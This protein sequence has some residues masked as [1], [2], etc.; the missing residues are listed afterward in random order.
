MKRELRLCQKT[1][2]GAG[3]LTKEKAKGNLVNYHTSFSHVQD[4][5][6][7]KLDGVHWWCLKH[8]WRTLRS[9]P[10]AIQ[11]SQMSLLLDASR[12][13]GSSCRLSF[14]FNQRKTLLLFE[15]DYSWSH[16]CTFLNLFTNFMWVWLLYTVVLFSAA[17]KNESA[18]CPH[19]SCA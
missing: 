11:K 18:T 1:G 5:L 12:L 17:Q 16:S 6:L 13:L 7:R 10:L 4:H 3:G 8:L 2:W 14:F 9:K 15:M 19:V